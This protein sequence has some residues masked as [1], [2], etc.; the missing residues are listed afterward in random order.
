MAQTAVFVMSYVSKKARKL[1]KDCSVR[2]HFAI[3]RHVCCDTPA[4][5][6]MLLEIFLVSVNRGTCFSGSEV[7][8][9]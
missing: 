1:R 8:F 6:G 2:S 3:R 9:V 7:R 5:V 4:T